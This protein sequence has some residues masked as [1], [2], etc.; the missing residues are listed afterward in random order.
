L[1]QGAEVKG[2]KRFFRKFFYGCVPVFR[3]PRAERRGA[4]VREKFFSPYFFGKP[5]V[6]FPAGADTFRFP[7]RD[8]GRETI[9]F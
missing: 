9:F 3:F 2:G 4:V 5:V 6:C 8:C 1:N 7:S